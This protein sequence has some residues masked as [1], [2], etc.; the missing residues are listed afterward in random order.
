MTISSNS[1]LRFMFILGAVVDGAIAVSWFLIAS[2][3]RM[4]ILRP[5]KT[6]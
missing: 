3:S 4:P 2:G 1:M 5:I 6:P